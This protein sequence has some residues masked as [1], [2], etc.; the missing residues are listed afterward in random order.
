MTLADRISESSLTLRQ[1]GTFKI[2]VREIEWSCYYKGNY[3]INMDTLT[4][5][6]HDIQTVSDSIFADKYLIDKNKKKVVP[7]R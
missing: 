6:R 1:N 7:A 5:T 2:Q 3:E 4:L